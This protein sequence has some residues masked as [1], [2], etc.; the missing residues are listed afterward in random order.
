VA[1]RAV[2]ARHGTSTTRHGTKWHD[3]NQHDGLVVPCHLV[4]PCR[5]PGTSTTLWQGIVSCRAKGTIVPMPALALRGT[6]MSN[7]HQN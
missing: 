2:P 6:N 1:K 7:I 5:S 3:T 4:P